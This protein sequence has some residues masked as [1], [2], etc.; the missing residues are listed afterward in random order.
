[1]PLVAGRMRLVPGV[2]LLSNGLDPSIPTDS[3]LA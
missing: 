2:V 1:M 3:P